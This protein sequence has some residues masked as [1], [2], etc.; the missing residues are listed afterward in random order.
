MTEFG[1]EAKPQSTDRSNKKTLSDKKVNN[2]AV[3]P[4]D[5]EMIKR[6][7]KR[8]KLPSDAW[9]EIKKDF[10]AGAGKDTICRKYGIKRSYYKYLKNLLFNGL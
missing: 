8:V 1:Y 9:T 7:L 3:D 6:T 2:K 5:V 4:H 10:K